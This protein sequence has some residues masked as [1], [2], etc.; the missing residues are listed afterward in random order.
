MTRAGERK[1]IESKRKARV[2]YL[3][4]TDRRI[5]LEIASSTARFLV[6]LLTLWIAGHTAVASQLPPNVTARKSPP[7][8]LCS[9]VVSV[10]CGQ[11]TSVSPQMG[12]RVAGRT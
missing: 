11:S 10:R 3:S 12:L 8:S 4:A 1:R 6:L 7:V 5:L 9:Y 2:P